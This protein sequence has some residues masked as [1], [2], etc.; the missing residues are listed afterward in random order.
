L[1]VCL[2]Y[3]GQYTIYPKGSQNTVMIRVNT[4]GVA[5][6]MILPS[7]NQ[8][9]LLTINGN[10]GDINQGI[11]LPPAAWFEYEYPT[12]GNDVISLNGAQQQVYLRVVVYNWYESPTQNAQPV[13][14]FYTNN[15]VF[16]G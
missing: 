14:Q 10:V 9:V 3:D 8:N 5:K 13:P 6:I 2:I 4:P 11:P 7:Q 15:V 12:L 1:T 16:T